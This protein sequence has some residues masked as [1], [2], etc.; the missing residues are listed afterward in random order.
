MAL[1]I[2]AE[3]IAPTISA[4]TNSQVSI[5]SC[6]RGASSIAATAVAIPAAVWSAP[7]TSYL[8][9]PLGQRNAKKITQRRQQRESE[10]RKKA[11]NPYCQWTTA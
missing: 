7:P 5:R 1:A 9:P 10:Y 6:E 2:L 4:T 3:Q 11:R 8:R